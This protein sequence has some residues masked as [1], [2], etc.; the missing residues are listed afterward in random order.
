MPFSRGSSR[1]GDGTGVS[2]I[3]GR[4]L[5][6]CTDCRLSALSH[7]RLQPGSLRTNMAAARPC[8]GL[9]QTR[10]SLHPRPPRLPIQPWLRLQRLGPR[11]PR[12]PSNPAAPPFARSPSAPAAPVPLLLLQILQQLQPP[13]FPTP[14][15]SFPR[16]SPCALC[17]LP[18]NQSHSAYTEGRVPGAGILHIECILHI[19]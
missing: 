17:N 5:A 3:A 10:L 19:E 2:C 9:S 14:R 7:L 13:D 12:R 18:R 6:Q 16:E 11:A 1:P 15:P 8:Q 4:F